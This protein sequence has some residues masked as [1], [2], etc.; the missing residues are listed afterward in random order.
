MVCK[1]CNESDHIAKTCLGEYE[2]IHRTTDVKE[3]SICLTKTKKPTCKTIC[4]HF[5]HIT[6]IKEWMKKSTDCP[7]CRTKLREEENIV[8][9]IVEE[10]LRTIDFIPT[11]SDL[12]AIFTFYFENENLI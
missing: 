9:L 3:C 8:E 7:L 2:C 6:C 10:I 11:Q 1:I 12:N 5:F 4:N